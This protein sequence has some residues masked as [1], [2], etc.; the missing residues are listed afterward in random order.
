M[1]LVK[2]IFVQIY[3]FYINIFKEKDIPHWFT[4]IAMA[5]ILSIIIIDLQL[6][7][8]VFFEKDTEL[9][10]SER[11]TFITTISLIISG[12][13][14]LYNNRFN[15]I[16]KEVNDFNKVKKKVLRISAITLYVILILI[17]IIAIR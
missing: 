7:Y 5:I 6:I 15:K 8:H 12:F 4:T 17:Y 9:T 3:K 16:I 11:S 14:F 2:Y 13:Y 1:V 10:L